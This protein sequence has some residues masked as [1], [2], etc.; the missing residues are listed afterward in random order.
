[1]KKFLL[2]LFTLLCST[3]AIAQNTITEKQARSVAEAFAKTKSELRNSDLVLVRTTNIFV[4][5]IGDHGYVMVSGDQVLPPVLGYSTKENFIP[6]DDAP[7][8]YASWIR[9]YDEM[10]DFAKERGI[11][12]EAEVVEQWDMAMR[13]D[14]GT[15]NQNTVAPLIETHW[16]QDC[17]YNEYCPYTGGGGW[18]DDGGPCGHAYA[19]CVACAMAQVMKYWNHPLHGFGSHSYTHPTYGLQTAN[20]GET[21]YHWIQMPNSIYSHNDAVA[22]LMYHCGVSVDMNYGPGGSGAQSK[23]VETAFRSYFGYCGAKYREKSKYDE[24]TWISLLKADLD[25]AHPIY[26]SGTSGSAGHAFVC[27]GYD[28]NDF[29]HFNF[30]WS[31]AGDNYYS[32][33]DVYGYNGNQAAVLNIV[34]IDIR[35]DANGIIYVSADGEGNGS[36]WDQST[37]FFEY[38]TYLSSGGNNRVWVKKG[39]YYGDDTDPE[40]AFVISA[41]NKIYGGFNGDEAPDFDL[42]QRDFVNNATILDGQGLKRVLNQEDLLSPSSRALWNGFTIRNGHSATGAGVYINGFVTLENCIFEDNVA[43]AFGGAVYVN[44]STNNNQVSLINCQLRRNTASIGGGLCDRGYT[45]LT[46]CI[47]AN[48][49]AITKGGGVYAYNNAMPQY[50]G[51]IVANNSANEGGGIYAR[52]KVQLLNCNVVMNEASSKYGGVYNEDHNSVYTSSIFWGNVSPVNNQQHEGPG[53]FLYCAVQGGMEGEGNI[54]LPEENDGDEPGMFVRFLSPAQY[55]GAAFS[56]ANWNI[57][58]RSICLNSGKPGTVGYSL[59]ML[60][61]QRVQHE[62]VDIGAYEKNASL[63]LIE[64][65]IYEDQ[66]YWFNNRPLHEPGYYTTV[67]PTSS[68]DSVVGLTLSVTL[69]TD[70]NDYVNSEVQSLKIYSLMGQLVGTANDEKAVRNLNLKPGCYLLQLQTSE[71]YINKKVIIP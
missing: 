62:R 30:G 44:S 13:G 17:Y 1:M 49:A 12:P 35:P 34:P 4:Y 51:C 15:R 23:D 11:H 68:C 41:S 64:A 16:N 22:T 36:S 39:I 57:S 21:T 28:D 50:R 6:V 25:Q 40:N 60:G 53:T 63:T 9:H 54:D 48:N 65:S 45:T 3:I 14:F 43:D 10:I 33:Y 56:E 67:Y 8:N 71:G 27:D 55:P 59:D 2:P 19:G 32:I 38:A 20:F 58:S 31:G 66:T 47:I 52:G 7:D 37:S 26:Y 46:N 69:G 18:W 42:S 29:F 61:H 70:E 5:D 24:A